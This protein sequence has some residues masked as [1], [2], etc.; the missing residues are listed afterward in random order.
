M[1]SELIFNVHVQSNQL[2]NGQFSPQISVIRHQ[3]KRWTTIPFE[4]KEEGIFATEEKAIEF[5]KQL[6]AEELKKKY[7]EAEINFK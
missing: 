3:D 6:A 5:G 2:P 4:M 1:E 7:P